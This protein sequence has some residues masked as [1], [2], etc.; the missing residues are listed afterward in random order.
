VTCI[1]IEELGRFEQPSLAFDV[2]WEARLGLMYLENQILLAE[3]ELVVMPFTIQS[4]LDSGA[5]LAYKLAFVEK[6]MVGH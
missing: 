6:Y 4:L 1:K 5:T 2:Q 3:D